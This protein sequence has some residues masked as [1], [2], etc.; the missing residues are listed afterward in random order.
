MKLLVFTNLA[1]SARDMQ[2]R[3]GGVTMLGYDSHAERTAAIEEFH[4]RTDTMITTACGVTGWGAPKGAKILFDADV[5]MNWSRE[6]LLQAM[7]RVQS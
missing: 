1:Q 7:G 3:I 5:M 4:S 6:M 2:K